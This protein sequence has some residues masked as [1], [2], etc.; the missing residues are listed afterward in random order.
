MIAHGSP[1]GLPGRGRRSQLAASRLRTR[2]LAVA[3]ASCSLAGVLAAC[4]FQDAG[5]GAGAPAAEVARAAQQRARAAAETPSIDAFPPNDIVSV[6]VRD[7]QLSRLAVVMKKTGLTDLLSD[8]GPYTVFAPS[9]A[10]FD[11]LGDDFRRLIESGHAEGL[12]SRMRYHVVR[13]SVAPAALRKSKVLKS[14]DGDPI[15]VE[16]R[17][18]K[19]FLNGR[20]VVLQSHEA[21][22]GWVYRIDTVLQAPPR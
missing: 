8:K 14:V 21:S 17:G 4:S 3:A 2:A 7:E 20:A 1:R 12:S 9:D 10:A 22:S 16:T 5:T 19:T 18:G 11:T 15:T 6:L 13:G